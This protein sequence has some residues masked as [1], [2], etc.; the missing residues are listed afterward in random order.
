MNLQPAPMEL[1]RSG[2]KTIELRLYDEKRRGISVG[3]TICF[4][5]TQTLET[6]RVRVEAL[7]VFDSFAQLYASLPLLACGYTQEDIHT[8]SPADMELYYPKEKQA[9]CG[10]VGIEISL[11]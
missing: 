1:I 8:A 9:N 2:R 7:H 4:H 3:D 6:L 5:N 10:V 11:L